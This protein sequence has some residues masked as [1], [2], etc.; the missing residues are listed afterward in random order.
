M[1][2][3]RPVEKVLGLTCS[4]DAMLKPRP[5]P[6]LSYYPMAI[7]QGVAADFARFN[8]NGITAWSLSA[9]WILWSVIVSLTYWAFVASTGHSLTLSSIGSFCM[10]EELH[11]EGIDRIGR[12][13]DAHS[14]LGIQ[15]ALLLWAS[16]LYIQ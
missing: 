5:K 16:I 15:S 14:L 4:S 12:G 10:K 8:I 11:I 7:C 1:R 9:P 2:D 6:K 13:T 3:V